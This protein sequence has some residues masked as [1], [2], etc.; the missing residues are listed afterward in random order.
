MAG[1]PRWRYPVVRAV[2]HV[3]RAH[4]T[5]AEQV[6]QPGKND[7]SGTPDLACPPGVGGFDEQPAAGP[8]R[9]LVT[10]ST[11][12]PTVARQAK[13]TLPA[14]RGAR[15]STPARVAGMAVC[16]GTSGVR[17]VRTVRS[18][19]LAPFRIARVYHRRP[20]TCC[21]PPPR[22]GAPNCSTAAGFRFDVRPVDLDETGSAGRS[23]GNLCPAVA[24][25]KV[26][27]ASRKSGSV[28]DW[29]RHG[30]GRGGAASR[31]ARRRAGR[32]RHAETALGTY[33]RRC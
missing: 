5:V 32:R 29:G 21:S 27:S 24:G 9:T 22:R 1:R 17:V 4:D 7:G 10:R 15:R 12:G 16:R 19:S 3:E 20:C 13:S 31:Q 25:E 26:R 33:A 30:G 8:S 28:R 23:A 11:A 14:E 2:A 6:G 18:G